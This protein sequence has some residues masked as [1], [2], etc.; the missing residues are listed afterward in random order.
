MFS[1]LKF[2]VLNP[3]LL[4]RRESDLSYKGKNPIKYFFDNF[5]FKSN[6]NPNQVDADGNTL[7]HL[8]V[9][10]SREHTSNYLDGYKYMVR[11]L[12]NDVGVDRDLKNNEN[13]T[14]YRLKGGDKTNRIGFLQEE[15]Q[16]YIT[17]F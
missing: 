15:I 11:F 16:E 14:A 3:Y 4:H 5:G 9:I 7:L 2:I 1:I 10:Q 6:I 17:D 13:L 8:L 12:I